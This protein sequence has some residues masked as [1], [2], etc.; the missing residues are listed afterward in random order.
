MTALKR[1]VDL[2]L[3]L[4]SLILLAMAAIPGGSDSLGWWGLF[5]M[6]SRELVARVM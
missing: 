5:V 4:T 1:V 3:L 2:L 6:F